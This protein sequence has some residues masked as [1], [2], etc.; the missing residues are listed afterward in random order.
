MSDSGCQFWNVF[1][2]RYQNLDSNHQLHIKRFKKWL[3]QTLNLLE[4]Y[5]TE[6]HAEYDDLL[7]TYTKQVNDEV[8]TEILCFNI[9]WILEHKSFKYFGVRL[10]T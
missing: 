2:L 7:N 8:V 10:L 1:V 3:K 6:T 5:A 9:A 4:E